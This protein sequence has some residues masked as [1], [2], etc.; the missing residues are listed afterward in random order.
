[1]TS[2]LTIHGQSALLM[3]S[4][5]PSKCAKHKYPVCLFYCLLF[6]QSGIFLLCLPLRRPLVFW[7]WSSLHL[8]QVSLDYCISHHVICLDLGGPQTFTASSRCTYPIAPWIP[9][10]AHPR[11]PSCSRAQPGE[12]VGTSQPCLKLRHTAPLPPWSPLPANGTAFHPDP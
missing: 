5:P 8:S 2:V 9:P 1:M 10:L 3:S 12:R 11:A 7:F 6:R 4:P